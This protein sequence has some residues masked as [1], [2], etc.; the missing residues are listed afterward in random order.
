MV[1]EHALALNDIKMFQKGNKIKC[2]VFKIKTLKL[3]LMKSKAL[4]LKK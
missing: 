3:T 1:I 2:L 4:F